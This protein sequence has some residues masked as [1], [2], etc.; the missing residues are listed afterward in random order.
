MRRLILVALILIAGCATHKR[1]Y[2][3]KAHSKKGTSVKYKGDL[4]KY[5]CRRGK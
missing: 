2:D 3:Y 4:T 5:K 1:G